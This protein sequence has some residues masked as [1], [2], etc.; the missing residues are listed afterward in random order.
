[1]KLSDSTKDNIVIVIGI[2]CVII[3][4]LVEYDLCKL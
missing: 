2:V 1:M 3:A 4:I